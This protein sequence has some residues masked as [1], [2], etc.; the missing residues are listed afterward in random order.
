MKSKHIAFICSNV[1]Q[2]LM[3][4][5]QICLSLEQHATPDYNVL[6]IFDPINNSWSWNRNETSHQKPILKG[7]HSWH[8]LCRLQ[9]WVLNI[10]CLLT[11]H[12]LVYRSHVNSSTLF[13]QSGAL[14]LREGFT[15]PCYHRSCSDTALQGDFW[16]TPDTHTHLNT[17]SGLPMSPLR[18]SCW[19]LLHPNPDTHVFKRCGSEYKPVN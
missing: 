19:S 12:A 18:P 14:W 11:A 17:H 6:V 16:P 5:E 13:N 9:Y 10:H 15:S 1:Y 3:S 8:F 7:I 2:F 4:S